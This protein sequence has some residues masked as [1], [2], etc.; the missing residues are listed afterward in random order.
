MKACE[1]STEHLRNGMYSWERGLESKVEPETIEQ[2]EL[3]D[4]LVYLFDTI[5]ILLKPHIVEKDNLLTQEA[6]KKKWKK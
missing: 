5:Q 6:W 3:T 2:S 4:S 1:V